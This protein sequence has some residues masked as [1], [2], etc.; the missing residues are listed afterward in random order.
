MK[1]TLVNPPL[2]SEE[3]YGVHFQSGGMTPP[4]GL[5]CLA[6]VTKKHGIDTRIVDGAISNDYEFIATKIVS[7]QPDYVGITAS[8]VS[9]F[10]AARVARM[11]K[12]RDSSIITL[13]GGPHITALP[14]DTMRQFPEFDIGVIGEAEDTI[15]ELLDKRN[16]VKGIIFRKADKIIQTESRPFIE[17][18]DELPMPA[19]ELLPGLAENYRPPAHTVKRLPATLMVTSRGCPSQCSF[20]DRSVFGNSLRA[21]SAGYVMSMVKKLYHEYAIRELQFRD[22]NFLAFRPRLVELCNLL[23]TEKL[24]ITWSLAGRVDMVNKEI[25]GLLSEAGCWQIW[26]GIESG[27]QRVLDFIQKRTQLDRIKE[28]VAQTREAGIEVGGFFMIGLPTETHKEV[29]STIRFSRELAL[30]E[31]HFTFFTPFP[32]CE[33]YDNIREYGE[34]DDDWRKTSCWNPVF[35]PRGMT[36]KQLVR[37]WKK[38]S[39]GFYLR[40]RIVLGYLRKVKSF[41]HIKIY[42]S[43]LLALLEAVSLKKYISRSRG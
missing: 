3:R 18:L 40:P 25:L 5:A 7:S 10:N 27:S 13:I 19:W 24:D 1:L 30:N 21:Y 6:A 29:Q 39:M 28:T 36:S 43:G 20:C 35:V 22:D 9:I 41:K 16:A 4:L 33:L 37:Y 14:M 26:Y 31:A 32:G 38:A 15:V 2:T 11:I 42:L 8:T 12:Q 23:K 34:F 17:D